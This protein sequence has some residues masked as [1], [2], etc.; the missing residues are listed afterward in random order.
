MKK[1]DIHITDDEGR[2]WRKYSPSNTAIKK[3]KTAVIE[4]YNS[5]CC[6][7]VMK[8]ELPMRTCVAVLNGLYE[9]GVHIRRF[10]KDLGPLFGEGYAFSL[11]DLFIDDSQKR[12]RYMFFTD[13]G[14]K[15]EIK[16]LCLASVIICI[17]S[18]ALADGRI[19]PG[20][21]NSVLKKYTKY[22]FSH[23]S[24]VKK[25][26]EKEKR[27]RE[28]ER[29]EWEMRPQILYTPMGNDRRRR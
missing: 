2:I 6:E 20:Y 3:N 21:Y 14:D 1:D 12:T 17:L 13:K 7:K 25:E 16:C 27:K 15:K 5:G 29:K 26:K 10:Y 23:L 9:N 28:Q 19:K 24:P 4:A 11:T 18:K 22:G 8:L